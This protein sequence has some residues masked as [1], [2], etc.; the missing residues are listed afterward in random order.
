[1]ENIELS[2]R[3]KQCR[4]ARGLSQAQLAEKLN[5]TPQTISKWERGLSL[6]D[7]YNLSAICSVL[8]VSVGFLLDKLFSAHNEYMIAIDGGGTKTEFVLFT[9]EGQVI[10]KQR[11]G[12]TNP[13]VCGIEKACKTLKEGIDILLGEYGQINFIYAGIAGAYSGKNKE[14][15]TNYLKKQYP[16]YNVRVESDVMNV[17]GLSQEGG[18]C[19]A[20]IVGTGSCVYGYDGK[21]LYRTGGW[22]YL[23]DQAGSG[24]YIGRELIAQTFASCD[25]L[26]PESIATKMVID[27]LGGKPINCIEN[28]YGLGSDYIASFAPIAF[29]AMQDGDK[30]AEKIIKDSARRIAQLI[31]F[32]QSKYSVGN[33]VIMSGSICQNQKPFQRLVSE[34]LGGNVI[35]E[36]PNVPQI[37]GAMKKGMEFAQIKY[38]SKNFTQNFTK[39][40]KF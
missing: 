1:M 24:Y 36:Y 13:N 2:R 16:L 40:Y 34:Y 6:P 10:A 11:L 15:L 39:T 33:R 4:T 37:L 7:L 9:E 32:V 14:H 18:K 23:F 27:K 22:G 38:S 20:C 26:Q 5:L 8:G 30:V 19:T 31:N 17:V 12:A 21:Q 28:L 29:K 25:G 35:I 3:L